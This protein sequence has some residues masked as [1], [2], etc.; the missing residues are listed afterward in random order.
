M[1]TFHPSS[2][3]LNCEARLPWIL[4]SSYTLPPKGVEGWRIESKSRSHHA[5]SGGAPCCSSTQQAWRS[6]NGR[7]QPPLPSLPPATFD[8]VA[9]KR[10]PTDWAH[11]LMLKWNLI[12]QSTTNM[13]AQSIAAWNRGTFCV[14]QVW[15]DKKPWPVFSPMGFLALASLSIP[16]LM[17]QETQ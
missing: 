2:C 7:I 11:H 4:T 3:L 15:S 6:R 1:F 5:Q 9:L 17:W 14:L 12:K 13:S 8:T 10:H 16:T